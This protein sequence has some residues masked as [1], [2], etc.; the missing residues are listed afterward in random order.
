MPGW[1]NERGKQIGRQGRNKRKKRG[2]RG[3][4]R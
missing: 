4:G 1:G 3:A 2:K